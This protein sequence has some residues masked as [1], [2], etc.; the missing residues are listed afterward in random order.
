MQLKEDGR[1]ALVNTFKRE[2]IAISDDYQ[3]LVK[4][5]SYHR[6]ICKQSV[7]REVKKKVFDQMLIR[8]EGLYLLEIDGVV[9]RQQDADLFIKLKKEEQTSLGLTIK[10]LQRIVDWGSLKKK[11]KD[12][13]ESALKVLY[14]YIDDEDK[15]LEKSGLVDL[16]SDIYYLDNLQ[17]MEQKFK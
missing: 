13:L 7:V 9:V 12:K 1:Y 10:G 3:L 5:M 14:K 2:V 4:F 17:E 16:C 15:L 11:E 6:F 8:F